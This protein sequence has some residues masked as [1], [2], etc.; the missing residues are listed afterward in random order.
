MKLIMF[1]V[2]AGWGFYLYKCWDIEN[3]ARKYENFISK[4]SLAFPAPEHNF[5]YYSNL[6]ILIQE[7]ILNHFSNIAVKSM[8]N[9]LIMRQKLKKCE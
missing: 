7:K 5:I 3:D 1:W 9:Y 8:I 2:C 6:F 4:L